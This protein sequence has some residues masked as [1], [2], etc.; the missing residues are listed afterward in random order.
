MSTTTLAPVTF[1][2]NAIAEINRLMQE[3]GFDNTK[4]FRVG[5]KGGGCSGM[6]YILCFDEQKED[7][8]LYQTDNFKFIMT[9]SHSIYLQGM[10]VDWNDGLNSRGFTFTNPSASKT[11]GCG[12][13][14]AV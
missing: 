9:Q 3:E 1:T 13:S 2:K 11:C 5:V 14:F 4:I 12:T 7:D 6:S 10:E 8:E